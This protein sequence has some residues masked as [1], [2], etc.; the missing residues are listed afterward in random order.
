[1]K[2][3]THTAFRSVLLFLIG[4]CLTLAGCSANPVAETGDASPAT[5]SEQGM[6]KI[7]VGFESDSPQV[8]TPIEFEVPQSTAVFIEV[9]NATGYHIKT[10]L[11]GVQEESVT[12][13]WNGS[14][15]DGVEV[16]TGIYMFHMTYDDVSNWTPFKYY[17]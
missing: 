1:M 16:A 3:K 5:A 15:E 7:T 10:L 12:I 2:I 17:Q 9:T 6:M 13:E 8:N 4:L 14:N 11:D